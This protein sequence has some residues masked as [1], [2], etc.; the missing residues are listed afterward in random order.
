MIYQSL[1]QKGKTIFR[2]DTDED[3]SHKLLLGAYIYLV[4][5]FIQSY[6]FPAPYGK[7]TSSSVSLIDKLRGIEFPARISWI[8]MEVPSFLISLSAILHLLSSSG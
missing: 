3:F 6:F 8:L 5:V 4:V 7:F 1:L 2:S